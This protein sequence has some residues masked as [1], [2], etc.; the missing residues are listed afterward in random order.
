MFRVYPK[1]LLKSLMMFLVI[2]LALS[3]YIASAVSSSSINVNVIPENYGPNQ[4]VTISLTSFSANLDSVMITWFVNGKNTLSGVGKKSFSITTGASGSSNTVTVK[5][6]LPDGEIEKIIPLNPNTTVL[7]YQA[8]ESHTPPFYKGK[9]LPVLG[10]EI[11]V[12]AMP[13][14]KNGNTL[15]NPKN[16]TY[17]WRRDYNNEVSGSGYGKNYFTYSDDYLEG[18]STVEVNASTASGQYSS[19]ASINVS[20]TE[21]EIFFYKKN[22]D[23]GISW[24]NALTDGH[25]IIND[26]IIVAIPYFISP[27]YIYHPDLVFTWSINNTQVNMGNF[28]KNLIPLKKQEGVSGKSN[29]KLEIE[30]KSQIFQ[31]ASKEIELNF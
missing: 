24:E 15:V 26:E 16:M 17:S 10:S 6:L 20:T 31:T 2:L 1:F 28:R 19:S 5:I 11:K 30:N 29:L 25:L 4:N 22:K 7:L 18:S 23:A 13:E 21:P 14:I 12:V 8:T 9:A 3:P 27:K